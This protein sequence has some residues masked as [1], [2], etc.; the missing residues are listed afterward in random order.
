MLAVP[1]ELFDEFD[2]HCGQWWLES[3]V[4]NVAV[5]YVVMC[6]GFLQIAGRVEEGVCRLCVI[7]QRTHL[8][9]SKLNRPRT[10]TV[11]WNDRI[12]FR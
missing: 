5:G 8:N 1:A 11:C 6:V 9:I 3:R 12:A 7:I 10:K 4:P 2:D